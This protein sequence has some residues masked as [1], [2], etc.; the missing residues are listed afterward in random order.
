MVSK[1]WQLFRVYVCLVLDC[2]LSELLF[3]LVEFNRFKRPASVNEKRHYRRGSDNAWLKTSRDVSVETNGYASPNV[4]RR[5]RRV[6]DTATSNDITDGIIHAAVNSSQE[7][8]QDLLSYLLQKDEDSTTVGAF[9]RQGSGRRRRTRGESLLT[10]DASRER[11]PSPAFFS[12]TSPSTG[13]FS[14]MENRLGTDSP[15]PKQPERRRLPAEPVACSATPDV[16]LEST[17][18]DAHTSS[19]HSMTLRSM[20]KQNDILNSDNAAKQTA[21]V[22]DS[23]KD[24]QSPFRRT[25]SVGPGGFIR[26]REARND[27]QTIPSPD[28]SLPTT[29]IAVDEECSVKSVSYSPVKHSTSSYTPSQLTNGVGSSNNKEDLSPAADSS[30]SPSPTITSFKRSQTLPRRWK[31]HSTTRYGSDVDSDHSPRDQVIEDIQEEPELS[32]ENT[33]NLTL[34]KLSDVGKQK[35]N[36]LS[37]MYMTSGEEVWQKRQPETNSSLTNSK[38]ITLETELPTVPVVMRQQSKTGIT[39]A[40]NRESTISSGRDEGFDS[41]RSYDLS[42]SQRT[43]RSSTF[44]SELLTTLTPTLP[45]LN[46]PSPVSIEVESDADKYFARSIDSLVNKSE[47]SLLQENGNRPSGGSSGK[48]AGSSST[49][50]SRSRSREGARK[51]STMSVADTHSDLHLPPISP[52]LGR[53]ITTLSTS[54]T[55][56]PSLP[57]RTSSQSSTNLSV[58]KSYE[59]SSPLPLHHNKNSS[60]SRPRKDATSMPSDKRRTVSIGHSAAPIA[61][62]TSKALVTA[63]T[64]SSKAGT[65]LKSGGNAKVPSSAQL[66]LPSPHLNGQVSPR[67]DN[68]T[69]QQSIRRAAS[70]SINNRSTSAKANPLPSF[71]RGSAIRSTLPADMLRA[72]KKA[73]IE[74][75]VTRENGKDKD[76]SLLSSPARRTS[77]RSF[78]STLGGALGLGKSDRHAT[79]SSGKKTPEAAAI[80]MPSA[81]TMAIEDGGER[82]VISV[83]LSPPPISNG[84]GSSSNSSRGGGSIKIVDVIMKKTGAKDAK[85]DVN[86]TSSSSSSNNSGS[87]AAMSLMPQQVHTSVKKTITGS[88]ASTANG[89]LAGKTVASS[90]AQSPATV[91]KLQ[92]TKTVGLAKSN[93]RLV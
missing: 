59:P 58:E 88:S 7:A 71:V 41:E 82:P 54:S 44:D 55:M 63:I 45:R 47:L 16:N 31:P 46:D 42:V 15:V 18:E 83:L 43:S 25:R 51:T 33:L 78:R 4:E 93:D 14:S 84:A 92:K 24:E 65:T 3:A 39:G 30:P 36:R 29:P 66:T 21:S 52:S 60:S 48:L 89:R 35:L 67:T 23:A 17:N 73:A 12:T 68:M 75:G 85:K 61:L 1:I 86:K 53:R 87:N 2:L 13:D 40:E 20:T 38:G 6:N 27:K 34:G 57:K 80:T 56:S 26:Y 81:S 50:R 22:G 37:Q 49:L 5:V 69:E 91:M 70:P 64:S 32:G 8:Q 19:T 76:A 77:S 28:A 11:Q 90:S 62:T 74:E 10:G 9:E 72:N 79:L